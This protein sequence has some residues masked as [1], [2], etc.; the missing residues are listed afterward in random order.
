MSQTQTRKIEYYYSIGVIH[1]GSQLLYFVVESKYY[2]SI[3]NLLVLYK[4]SAVDIIICLSGSDIVI[5]SQNIF[6]LGWYCGATFSHLDM[7]QGHNYPK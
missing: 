5:E 2:Y 4:S 1:H 7:S 3:I 6:D